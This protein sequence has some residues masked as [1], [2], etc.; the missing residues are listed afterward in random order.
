M[1]EKE[2]N[3]FLRGVYLEENTS[4]TASVEIVCL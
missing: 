4:Q 1:Q 3:I 2:K